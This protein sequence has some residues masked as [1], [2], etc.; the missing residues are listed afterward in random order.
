MNS[1]ITAGMLFLIDW[2]IDLIKKECLFTLSHFPSL[3][4]ALWLCCQAYRLQNN[5]ERFHSL[6]SIYLNLHYFFPLISAVVCIGTVWLFCLSHRLWWRKR[7]ND[8]GMWETSCFYR[9]WV[10]LA[11]N[12]TDILQ[13]CE[14]FNTVKLWLKHHS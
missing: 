9:N 6:C 11:T 2:L 1:L 13:Y 3:K 10:Q 7:S 4:L 12:T 5:Y 8:I 14:Y